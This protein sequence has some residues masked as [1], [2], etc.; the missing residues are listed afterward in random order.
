[1]DA[2]RSKLLRRLAFK[3][4][5]WYLRHTYLRRLP[6]KRKVLLMGG[7]GLALTGALAALAARLRG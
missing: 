2:Q 5:W 7:G 4:G 3:G 1:V 6:S